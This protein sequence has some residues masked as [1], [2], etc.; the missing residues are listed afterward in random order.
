L[1]L[2]AGHLGIFRTH[3]T[4]MEAFMGTILAGPNAD[5]PSPFDFALGGQGPHPS[6]PVGGDNVLLEGNMT[7]M[8]DFSA[9]FEG[10]LS[11]LTRT[12]SVDSLPDVAYKAHNLSLTIQDA[13]AKEGKPGAVCED[14]YQLSLDMAQEAGLSGHF[15]GHT[16]QSGFVGHGLGLEIN[17]LP[18]LCRKNK[19]ALEENMVIALEPKFVFPEFGAAGTENTYIV[20]KTGMEKITIC[21]EEIVALG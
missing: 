14:L 19:T 9:N 11:D 18:V 20:T 4:H 3:G 8:A 6:L 13:I 10:Y 12:Y 15:M 7:I 16:K 21:P 2:T 1:L 5:A 17:E